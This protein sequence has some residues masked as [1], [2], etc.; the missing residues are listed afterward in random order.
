MQTIHHLSRYR[1]LLVIVGVHNITDMSRKYDPLPGYV[2]GNPVDVGFE[3]GV[4]D[5]LVA[6]G[7]GILHA[8]AIVLRVRNDGD[9]ERPVRGR[10][11]LGGVCTIGAE[12]SADRYDCP[13]EL[14]AM[15][16]G[17]VFHGLN[18]DKRRMV[19]QV[20]R[21]RGRERQYVGKGSG[22]FFGQ[23]LARSHRR[24][25]EKD[26]RPSLERFAVVAPG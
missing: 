17:Q 14:T 6:L 23:C 1:P 10:R 4:G 21:L 9:A 3:D 20:T 18:D 11:E 22:V 7:T 24:K 15:T 16:G 26:S 2:A 12:H 8:V 25:S 19:E 13:P 5:V